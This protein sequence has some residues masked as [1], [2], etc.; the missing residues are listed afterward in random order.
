MFKLIIGLFL[1]AVGL[2]YGVTPEVGMTTT[3]ADMHFWTGIVLI[4]M[5][6]DDIS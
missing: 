6:V 2:F 5:G 3:I 1:V 4:V